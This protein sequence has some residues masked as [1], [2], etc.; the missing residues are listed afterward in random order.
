MNFRLGNARL[1]VHFHTRPRTERICPNCSSGCMED[2]LHVILECRAYN[3]VRRD[4]RFVE[5]FQNARSLK[6]FMNH[7]DQYLI[8]HFLVALNRRRVEIADQG[9]TAVLDLFSSDTDSVE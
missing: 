2:E 3:C 4:S 1:Q 6:E 9:S 7:K 5:L 8:A